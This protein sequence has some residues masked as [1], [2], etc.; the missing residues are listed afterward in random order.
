M[1]RTKSLEGESELSRSR[2]FAVSFGDE[3]FVSS[4]FKVG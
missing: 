2:E 1:I 4:F 3:F